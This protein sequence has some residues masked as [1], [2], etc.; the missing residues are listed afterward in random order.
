VRS[1]STLTPYA[2]QRVTWTQIL[3]RLDG[4]SCKDRAA[5][6]LLAPRCA[7]GFAFEGARRLSAR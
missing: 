6:G 2:V 7:N 4:V 5:V 3:S 1:A